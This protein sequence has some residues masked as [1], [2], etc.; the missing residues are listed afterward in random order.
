MDSA[1]GE[2]QERHRVV[3]DAKVTERGNS[4]EGAL[5]GER[6]EKLVFYMLYLT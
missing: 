5:L 6:M 4:G 1:F 2:S 3:M